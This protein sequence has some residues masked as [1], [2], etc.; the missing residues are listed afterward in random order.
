MFQTY[1]IVSCDN[2]HVPLY[3]PGNKRKRKE[4]KR[5][6]KS[7]KIDKRKL[8]LKLNIRVQVYHD[9]LSQIPWFSLWT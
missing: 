5:E 1:N 7:K 6:I 3:C 2:S 9:I 8:K 4:R